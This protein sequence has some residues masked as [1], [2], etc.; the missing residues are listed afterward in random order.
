M[1]WP[2]V[3]VN[4]YAGIKSA[5]TNLLEAA[6]VFRTPFSKKV[7]YIYIPSIIPYFVT[8]CNVGLGLGWKAGIA[9]EVIVLPHSTIG[10]QLYYA[11]LYLKTPDVFAYTAVIVALSFIFE[12]L[13]S[14]SLKKIFIKYQKEQA[15]DNN[16]L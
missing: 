8:A 2:V 15:D 11:K 4:I 5:D 1:I 12:K 9:A 10:E 7:K 13:F 3:Y 14:L 16:T 6:S